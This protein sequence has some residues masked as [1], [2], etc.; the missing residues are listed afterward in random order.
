MALAL[1]LAQHLCANILKENR[2]CV[3]RS[4]YR[5][6]TEDEVNSPE[7][8]RKEES[9]DLMIYSKLGASASKQ[10]FEEDYSSPEFELYEDDEGNE[11]LHAKECEAEPTTIIYNTY[12]GAEV[13]LQNG[14]H[15][16][17]GMVKS[18][19]KDFEGQP[20]GKADK[21]P[22]L[23]TRVYNVE[24]SDGENEKLGASIIAGYMYV[25]CDIE[26]NQYRLMDHIV[27]HR[28]DNNV[29]CK[30]SKMLQ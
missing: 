7:E 18:R 17:S 23:N 16:I 2:R 25:Q 8:V 29:V 15:M 20:N 13:A 9:Y 28:K 6:L 14:N 21:N 22:I 5:H 10:D 3:Y 30:I 12:I 24:F 1:I 27:A 26:G 11:V 4:S 19:V